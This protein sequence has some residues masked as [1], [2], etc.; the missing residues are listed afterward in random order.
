MAE[1]VF[2]Y[3]ELVMIVNYMAYH[4]YDRSE[5]ARAVEKPH[6]YLDVLEAAK[7]ELEEEFPQKD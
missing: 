7:E 6:N 2:D 5:I 1:W 3:D 4:Q